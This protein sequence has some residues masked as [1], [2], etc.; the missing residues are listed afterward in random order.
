MRRDWSRYVARLR[1]DLWKNHPQI[2]V[3]D[4][5]FYSMDIFKR[6]EHGRELLMAIRTWANVHPLLR[7]IP[8]A[9]EQQIPYGLL[10][11]LG[12]RALSAAFWRLPARP[13]EPRV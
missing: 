10:H 11:A 13:R 4:F 2:H 9:W 6:C 3:V 8:V 7:V 1:D 5:D 12:L